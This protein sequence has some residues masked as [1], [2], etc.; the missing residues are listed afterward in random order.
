MEYR[1]RSTGRGDLRRRDAGRERG[2]DRAGHVD[3][4]ARAWKSLV[5]ATVRL[6]GRVGGARPG[7]KVLS[8]VATILAGGIAHRSRRHA[9]RWRDA[10]SVAVSGDGALDVGLVLARVHVRA[11]P[12]TRQGD[13]RDVRGAWSNAGAGPGAEAMTIDLDSTIVRGARQTET[14]CR[15][16]LH[17][18]LGYHPLLATRA[19]DRRGAPRT[20]A[21]GIEPTRGAAF[22][23]RTDRP[24]ATRRRHRRGR[25][26]RRF[27]VL[28]LCADR[29][30]RSLRGRLVRSPSRLTTPLRGLH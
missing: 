24:G 28:V 4:P 10:T 5:N 8:L 23:R 1:A 15:L 25:A 29:H 20:A 17:P 19:D 16:R 21:Q 11:C 9:A 12:S 27:G 13:R 22:R 18:Q 2:A 30:A 14:G 3:G 26:A 6:S 7:R